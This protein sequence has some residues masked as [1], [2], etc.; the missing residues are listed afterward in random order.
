MRKKTEAF[1]SCPQ[2]SLA[3]YVTWS[4]SLSQNEKDLRKVIDFQ[5][6]RVAG[7]LGSRRWLRQ[8][9]G[10]CVG[11]IVLRCATFVYGVFVS[12]CEAVILCLEH[13]MV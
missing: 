6:I 8:S 5:K 3:S 4:I 11:N 2:P 7:S 10:C 13:L 12:L 1:Q 9:R